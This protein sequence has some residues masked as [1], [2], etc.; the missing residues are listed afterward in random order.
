MCKLAAS[1]AKV[2]YL[3]VNMRI[4]PKEKRQTNSFILFEIVQGKMRKIGFLPDFFKSQLQC[5]I[6][7]NATLITQLLFNVLAYLLA[8][9]SLGTTSS[10]SSMV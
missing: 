5:C 3:L 8:L 2:L 4:K 9:V 7:L 6:I 10:S 1:E